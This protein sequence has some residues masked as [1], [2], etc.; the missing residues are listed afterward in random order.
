MADGNVTPIRPPDP[1][2]PPPEKDEI[3]PIV[4]RIF[5][6][7]FPGVDLLGFYARRRDNGPWTR[8][9]HLIVFEGPVDLILGFGLADPIMIARKPKRLVHMRDIAGGHGHLENYWNT[10]RKRGDRVEVHRD[11][12]DSFDRTH[13]LAV[14]GVW[15]WPILE[16]ADDRLAHS[17]KLAAEWSRAIQRT[18]AVS[19][20]MLRCNAEGTSAEGTEG[21][22]SLDKA[23]QARIRAIT[24]AAEAQLMEVLNS[25]RVIDRERAVPALS[26]VQG[27]AP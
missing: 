18:C 23:S 4:A 25:A 21:R 14:F 13:P 9:T 8:D 20:K 12:E 27:R 16:T 19:M 22:F 1:P 3:D 2:K 6:S 5:A 10:Q 11:L 26:L 17:R 24:C 7:R 15:E